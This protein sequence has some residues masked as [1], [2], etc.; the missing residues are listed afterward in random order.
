[1]R[2]L[3]YAPTAVPAPLFPPAQ[4]PFPVYTEGGNPGNHYVP[5]GYMG[6]HSAV[7]M[8]QYW[9]GR[10]HSGKTCVQVTYRGAVPGGVGWAGVYWQSPVDNWGTVPGPAAYDLRRATRLTFWVRGQTG[11][12]RIQF[13]VG[14]ITGPYGD[15]LQPAVKTQVLQLSTAWQQVTI[16]LA[17]L[18]LRHIIGG[19]GWVANAPNDPGGAVFYLD[20]IMYSA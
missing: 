8:N 2:N 17:G 20:N 3:R 13:L 10:P 11:A 15:S 6:D 14:G 5:S 4:M 18:D 12:E 19:F 7:T 16:P 1:M 9:A